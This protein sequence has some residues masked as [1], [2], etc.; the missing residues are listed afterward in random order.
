MAAQRSGNESWPA[1]QKFLERMPEVISALSP[2]VR[3]VP[4]KDR[5]W[6]FYGSMPLGSNSA[7]SDVDVL[8]LHGGESGPEPHRRSGL[9]GSV[10]AT[11]YV[12]S[13]RDL[14]DDGSRRRFGGYFA[15]KLFSP[16]VSDRQETEPDLAVTTACFLGPF[17]GARAEEEEPGQHSWS[18]DQLVAHAYLAFLDLYPDFVGYLAR[19]LRNRG[20]FPQIWRHQRRVHVDALHRAG[21]VIPAQDELW[22]YTGLEPL[23]DIEKVRAHSTARFWAFGAVC[24]HSDPGFPD[25]YFRKANAHASREE[26]AAAVGFLH[27]QARGRENG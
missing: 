4:D 7:G 2:L 6:V 19:L 24:H 15:L 22:C 14:A 17:S 3:D 5:A 25:L 8:L 9:W 12:L 18:A 1:G 10:P 16:F 21:L 23:A 20:Q 13:H 27:R 26:Q 11:V